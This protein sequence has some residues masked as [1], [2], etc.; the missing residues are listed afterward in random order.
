MDALFFD[1]D[2]VLVDSEDFWIASKE[3]ELLEQLGDGDIT[4]AETTGMN[5]R[6]LYDYLDE[7]YDLTMDREAFLD[8]YERTAQRIYSEEVSMLPGAQDLIE[9]VQAAGVRVGLVSS[10]PHD[11]IDIV[12]E[13]FGLSVDAVISADAID[14]PAKPE[15]HVYE[16]AAER[17]GVEPARCTAVEDSRPGI[18]AASRAGMHVVGFRYGNDD[19]TDRSEADYVAQSPED[20][21]EYLR[22]RADVTQ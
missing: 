13:R 15:P 2:G 1:M 20:L 21:R 7:N 14:Q 18:E 8:W 17:L 5:Y 22:S 12:Q 4:V 10:S 9:E 16:S 3:A 6:E 11:W 19:D